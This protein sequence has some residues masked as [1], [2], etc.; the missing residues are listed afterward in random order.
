MGFATTALPGGLLG[1]LLARALSA[2]ESVGRWRRVKERCGRLVLLVRLAGVGAMLLG[3]ARAVESTGWAGLGFLG[4]L[5]AAFGGSL[6]RP[7]HLV[8]TFMEDKALA[9]RSHR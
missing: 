8:A 9:R 3:G 5:V 2:P 1:G 7:L 4:F 6:K